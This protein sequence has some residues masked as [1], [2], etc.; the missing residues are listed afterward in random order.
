[1]NIVNY[2]Y[3]A[4]EYYRILKTAEGE[5]SEMSLRLSLRT[6]K[7]HPHLAHSGEPWA[8]PSEFFTENTKWDIASAL[9]FDQMDKS[10]H[11]TY[12]EPMT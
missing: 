6:Q 7:R 8:T 5:E 12:Y 10:S 1:M 3:I 9:Y 4:V 2:R 11:D